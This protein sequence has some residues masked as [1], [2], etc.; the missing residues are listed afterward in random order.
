MN[1]YKKADRL[2]FVAC[3]PADY[4]LMAPC[5][6]VMIL[7]MAAMENIISILVLQ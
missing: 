6:I 7:I 4:L 3:L 5:L 1:T 2:T